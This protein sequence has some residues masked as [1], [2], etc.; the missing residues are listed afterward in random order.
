MGGLTFECRTDS[1]F[2]IMC[3]ALENNEKKQL[4]DTINITCNT[5]SSEQSTALLSCLME[6][7]SPYLDIT[8]VALEDEIEK[9]L[10][11]VLKTTTEQ[12]Q[13]IHLQLGS[14][15]IAMG[16]KP[17]TSQ[18]GLFEQLYGLTS[19]FNALSGMSSLHQAVS[20]HVPF[21]PGYQNFSLSQFSCFAEPDLE[22]DS[23]PESPQESRKNK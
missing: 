6:Y 16:E 19:Q 18:P 1:D 14:L 20:D 12:F 2:N 3:E 22:E 13:G 15:D 4:E 17:A 21:V 5:L 11:D 9:Q 23:R 10:I 8:V 7:S